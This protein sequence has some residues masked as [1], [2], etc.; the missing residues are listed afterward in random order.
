MENSETYKYVA[1]MFEKCREAG[2]ECKTVE[3]PNLYKDIINLEDT[4]ETRFDNPPY[5]TK[6]ANGKRGKL[7]QCCTAYYKIAPMDR[8]IRRILEERFGISR[9]SGRIGTGI[10]EKWIGFAWD[11]QH[12]IKIPPQK[13]VRFRYPLVEMR[14]KTADVVR[15]F[16]DNSLPIP[17]RSVCN[18][19]FANN[20]AHFREMHENRPEDWKQAVAADKAVRDW[21]QIGVE[22]EVF[23]SKSLIPLEELARRDFK[24]DDGEDD[25]WCQTGYCFT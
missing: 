23:V 17:P 15:F 1:M 5:W 7:M 25:D 14:M 18:A 20:L 12:R 10:V 3:G 6:D 21:K 9:K 8:E 19:C 4:D 13:Y 22:N 11:E 16:D 24:A 2:I